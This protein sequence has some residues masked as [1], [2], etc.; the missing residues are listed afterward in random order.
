MLQVDLSSTF[1]PLPFRRLEARAALVLKAFVLELHGGY[2]ATW[3][4]LSNAG[5]LSTMFSL[6]PIAG[7]YLAVG[8]AL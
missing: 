3:L 4:D 7:P 5:T 1:T 2:Q 6:A 8:V